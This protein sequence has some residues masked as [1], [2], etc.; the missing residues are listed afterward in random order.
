MDV[1]AV[2]D[3]V[4][5]NLATAQRLVQEARGT[6]LE[7]YGPGEFAYLDLVQRDDLDGT[8]IAT[9]WELHVPMAVAS[10]KA[11]KYA[12]LEVGPASSVEECWDLVRTHEETG[13]PC[14]FLEN[15]CYFRYNMAVL[16]MVRE[17]IFGEVVHCQCGYGHGLR[18]RIV[19]EKGTRP[20]P[21][22]AGDYRST[23]KQ[24]RNVGLY[25]THG[26]GP[27]AQCLNTQRGNRFAYLTSTATKS[28]GLQHWSREN[29][30]Y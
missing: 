8:V 18:E 17:G 9:P 5:R 28:R 6:R 20:M 14:M 15:Y 23:H 24:Y 3:L 27:I 25:P 30:P 13:V 1:P 29:L 2:S 4:P 7:S 26:V 10:M 16:K 21:K 22:G 11:G 19:L 12:A